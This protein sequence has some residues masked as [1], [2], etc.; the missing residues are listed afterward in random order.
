MLKR[1]LYGCRQQHACTGYFQR[2]RAADR[3]L[4][5]ISSNNQWLD[6]GKATAEKLSQGRA[7]TS[8]KEKK[9]LKKSNKGLEPVSVQNEAEADLAS[10]EMAEKLLLDAASELS[11]SLSRGRFVPLVTVLLASTA[12]LVKFIGELK[13]VLQKAVEHSARAKARA[14]KENQYASKFELTE[15]G[16]VR[17]ET[18]AKNISDDEDDDDFGMAIIRTDSIP[19]KSQVTPKS[20]VAEVKKSKKSMKQ[21]GTQQQKLSHQGDSQ[22]GDQEAKEYMEDNSQNLESEKGGSDEV[23]NANKMKIRKAS[24]VGLEAK[25]RVTNKRKLANTVADD[26]DVQDEMQDLMPKAKRTVEVLKAS[27]IE[28][29]GASMSDLQVRKIKKSKNDKITKRKMEAIMSTKGQ[30]ASSSTSLI[31][32]EDE[33]KQMKLKTKKKT[34]VVDVGV[35]TNSTLAE[36]KT[37]SKIKKVKKKKANDIDDIFGGL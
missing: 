11:W 37:K 21:R 4:R 28:T 22:D 2:L 36:K 17:V 32:D 31:E 5:K 35:A 1:L 16:G 25:R 27:V 30:T 13:P 18:F 12:Q 6:V 26:D 14:S 24:Q 20:A 15:D 23:S 29:D 10:L 33:S 9:A 19:K 3:R 7:A 34:K 8:F